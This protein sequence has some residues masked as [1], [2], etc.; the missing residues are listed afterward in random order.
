MRYI[1]SIFFILIYINTINAVEFSH[2]PYD[3]TKSCKEC[4]DMGKGKKF[5]HGPVKSG[6]CTSCHSINKSKSPS[7]LRAVSVSKMC[8]LCH[9]KKA[10]VIRN[11]KHVHPPVKKDCT[12]CHDP[13]A[14]DFKFRLKADSKKD[15]CLTCHV[16][17]KEQITSVKNQHGA[18]DAENGGCVACH[19]PHGTGKPKMIKADNVKDL[20]IKCHNQT[21][22]RDEDG[23][24][25]LNIGKHLKENPDWHGPILA[26]DCAACHNPHGTNYHRML[27]Q[28]FPEKFY[29][30]FDPKKYICFQCHEIEKFTDQFT[31]TSTNFRNGDKNI[32]FVHVNREKGI[33]CRACH[34]FHATK[35]YP[36][37]IAKTT[38]FGISKLP[39]RYIET[40]NGGSCAPVCH[41]RR[42]YDRKKAIKNLR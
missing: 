38:S 8:T 15:L 20:C 4:H 31:T 3:K 14:G 23:K 32:H 16:E 21:L 22:T 40:P 10:I 5:V 29:T 9:Y 27:K 28:P 36:H 39:L 33:T 35:D 6:A 42:G 24:K 26:G 18:I 25:L 7:L 13:H 2:P 17:K 34:D 41:V 12:G 11:D 30:S 1:L 37:H 19:D